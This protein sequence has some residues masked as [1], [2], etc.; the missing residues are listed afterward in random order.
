MPGAATYCSYDLFEEFR[1]Y[2]DPTLNTKVDDKIR[3]HYSVASY[4]ESYPGSERRRLQP[5][6]LWQD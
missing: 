3:R 1:D 5:L 2:K 6:C 4:G